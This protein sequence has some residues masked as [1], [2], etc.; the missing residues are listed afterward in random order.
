MKID[1]LDKPSVLLA[2]ILCVGALLS[3]QPKGQYLPGQFGLNAGITP[4]PGFTYTNMDINYFADTL[5][6]ASGNTTP[7]TGTYSL[8]D[9]ENLFFYEPNF[10]RS[11]ARCCLRS[12]RRPSLTDQVSKRTGTSASCSHCSRVVLVPNTEPQIRR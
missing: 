2:L 6:D 1:F 12:S 10:N 4:E 8:W 3:A 7:A 5:K 9:V 11:A